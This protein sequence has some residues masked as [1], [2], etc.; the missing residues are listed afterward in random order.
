LRQE[1]IVSFNLEDYLIRRR[2]S[3]TH[4]AKKSRMAENLGSMNPN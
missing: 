1:K 4:V 3:I 2:P